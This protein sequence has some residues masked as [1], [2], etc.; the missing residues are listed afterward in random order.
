MH[1][2]IALL[3][4]KPLCLLCFCIVLETEQQYI[5]AAKKNDVGTM[6]ALGKRVNANAMNV[7]G[8]HAKTSN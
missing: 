7:V 5:E 2:A 1:L 4:I 8:T 3:N 6:Q